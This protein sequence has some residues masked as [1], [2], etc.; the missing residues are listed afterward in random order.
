[1]LSGAGKSDANGIYLDLG[2]R[3][4]RSEATAKECSVTAPR[5]MAVTSARDRKSGARFKFSKWWKWGNIPDRLGNDVWE[6]GSR[7]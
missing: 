4:D 6:V 1:M 3:R 7:K 2:I 5:M